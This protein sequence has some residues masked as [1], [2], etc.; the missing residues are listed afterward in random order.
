MAPLGLLPEM[1]N[2]RLIVSRPGAIDTLRCAA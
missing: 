2:P 1:D